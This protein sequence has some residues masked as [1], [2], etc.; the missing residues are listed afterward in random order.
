MHFNLTTTTER[1]QFGDRQ[2]S[3]DARVENLVETRILPGT[4][5]GTAGIAPCRS[6]WSDWLQ[7]FWKRSIGPSMCR[8]PAYAMPRAA[9]RLS[10]R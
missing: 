7:S 3:T 5:A 10:S 4:C 9:A 1:V 8:L 2:S 6:F